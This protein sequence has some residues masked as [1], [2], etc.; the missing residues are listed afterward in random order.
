MTYS[1]HATQ[2]DHEAWLVRHSTE[3]DLLLRLMFHTEWFPR[4]AALSNRDPMAPVGRELRDRVFRKP[5]AGRDLVW[6][7]QGACELLLKLGI[8][9]R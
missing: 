6:A 8:R 7:V 3:K 9:L 2:I 1:A 5:A 4:E